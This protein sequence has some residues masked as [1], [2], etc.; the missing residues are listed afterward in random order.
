MRIFQGIILLFLLCFVGLSKTDAAV[1]ELD[2]TEEA[3][4]FCLN[5]NPF[6]PN[7]LSSREIELNQSETESE[8]EVE[9]NIPTECLIG[10]S[11]H[12][13]FSA[14]IILDCYGPCLNKQTHKLNKNCNSLGRY[15]LYCNFRI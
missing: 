6:F 12:S 4:S 13:F 3:L 9:K 11:D 5:K 14:F 8:T 7:P 10:F 15:L 2:K 1:Y